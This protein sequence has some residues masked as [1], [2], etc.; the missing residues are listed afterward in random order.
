MPLES[1]VCLLHDLRALQASEQCAAGELD[2][3]GSDLDLL[4]ALEQLTSSGEVGHVS[5][6]QDGRSQPDSHSKQ[7]RLDRISQT[8]NELTHRSIS[9]RMCSWS[10]AK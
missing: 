4:G 3:A 8:S 10:C 6:H 9:F 5:H 1:L 2:A 7:L